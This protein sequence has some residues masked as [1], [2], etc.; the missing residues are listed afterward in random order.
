MNPK[1]SVVIPLYNHQRFIDATLDSVLAQSVPVTE[2]IV[3]DDGSTDQSWQRVRERMA[4][5]SR[6]TGWSQSNQGA[7]AALNAGIAAARGDFIAIL[8]SD[9]LYHPRRFEHCL[10][11]LATQ[12]EVG[13]V[14]TA[15]DFL[16]GRGRRRNNPWYE[17]ALDFYHHHEDLSLALVNGNFLMTTSNLFCRRE[18]F[19]A[20]EPFAA[21]RYAHDLDFF[22][23]LSTVPGRLLWL[24]Q[25]LLSYRLHE[26][27]TINESHARVKL[28]WAAVVAWF[29]EQRAD[30][31]DWGRQKNYA[32]V[33]ER[34]QLSRLLC[35]FFLYFHSR[36]GVLTSAAD[37]MRDAGFV[38]LLEDLSQ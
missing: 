1:I 10:Q 33:F 32:E 3:V 21:L 2:I 13:V 35:Y 36:R 17:Q 30:E 28:E 8:N 12:P 5:E 15:I 37:P 31:L 26:S 11:A 25:P 20:A 18:L 16:D 38:S 29:M 23:R 24:D 27:N 22:L 9:D 7:H 14:C 4:A 19:A 34:H 6:I